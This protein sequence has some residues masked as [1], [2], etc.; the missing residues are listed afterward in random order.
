MIVM[1][2]SITVSAT[3]HAPIEKVWETWTEPKHIVHW[4]HTSDDWE[5]PHARNDVTVGGKFNFGMAAKDGSAKFDFEGVYTHVKEHEL[6][7]YTIVGGRKVTIHLV[8]QDENTKVIETFEME[9]E[10]SEEMQR[11]GWQAILDNFK[12]YAEGKK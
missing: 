12:K 3:I 5:T 11:N 2:K 9:N 6:I 8:K 1:V 4:N 7:K 10:N